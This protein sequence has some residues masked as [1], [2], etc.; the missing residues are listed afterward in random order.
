MLKIINKDRIKK[1]FKSLGK[2]F[3][4]F[5]VVFIIFTIIYSLLH[6]FLGV[7]LSDL[8]DKD[9]IQAFIQEAGGWGYLIY[10]L[11]SFLQVTFIPLPGA[12][13]VMIGNYLFGFINTLWMST[14]GVILGS[15]LAFFIGRKVGRPFVNWVVGDK[16]LV[17][18]YLKK[19]EGK[20]TILFFLMLIFP[21]F[22]D[23]PLCSVAGI[24][25]ITFKKF[26]IVQLIGRPLSI[27]GTL[28]FTTGEIIP[29]KG[30]GILVLILLFLVMI[31]ILLICFNRADEINDFFN[32]VFKIKIGKKSN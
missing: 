27:I 16:N 26:L 4:G 25:K 13:S 19:V 32:S 20:E 6:I 21:F 10:I 31:L 12:L 30:W 8:K 17:D 14:L 9:K 11:I 2:L 15:I 7:N 29:F 24:T 1:I 28:F 5:L 22:P 23:D 3:L 18:K